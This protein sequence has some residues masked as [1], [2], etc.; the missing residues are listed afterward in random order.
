MAEINQ[1]KNPDELA[2]WTHR[3]FAAKNTLTTDDAKTVELVYLEVL[4]AVP[5]EAELSSEPQQG[6]LNELQEPA[7]PRKEKVSVKA[8]SSINHQ[9]QLFTPLPKSTR[10]RSKAHLQFVA[11]QPCLVCQRS[12]CDAH[13]IKFAEPRALGRKVSDE[14]TVPLCREHHRQL[15][16]HGNEKAWWANVNVSPL[17]VAR[18]L[19]DTTI[20]GSG[21]ALSI[22]NTAHDAGQATDR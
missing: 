22:R 17:E 19:W 8:A 7:N 5:P 15:H 4:K 13:H 3:R 10:A 20:S 18:S 6:E 12:P 21:N 16:R 11:T 9:G 1:V 14:Y 2:R